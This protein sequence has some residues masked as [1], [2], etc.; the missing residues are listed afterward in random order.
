MLGRN[1]MANNNPRRTNGHRRTQIRNRLK[2]MGL[3][4]ALCGQPIDYALP[5]GHPL[6]F[7]VD[8]IIPVSRGGSP[9]KFSNVQPAHRICNARK[10]NKLQVGSSQRKTSAQA[11]VMPPPAITTTDW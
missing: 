2:S 11:C 6:S 8:E 3:P 9:F 5:P 10:G 7:E 4:C 1:N